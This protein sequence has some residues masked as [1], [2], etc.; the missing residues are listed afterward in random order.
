MGKKTKIKIASISGR[1]VIIAT[2]MMAL[3]QELKL[4]RE[5]IESREEKAKPATE[6]A[7]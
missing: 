7:H 4:L 6:K 1:E 5:F 3:A 2:A